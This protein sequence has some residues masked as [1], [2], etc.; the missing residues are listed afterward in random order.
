MEKSFSSEKILSERHIQTTQIYGFAKSHTDTKHFPV[1]FLGWKYCLIGIG[2]PSK[3]KKKKFFLRKL[4]IVL[5]SGC[6]NLGFHQ[7][8]RRVPFSPSPLHRLLFVDFL[9]MAILTG[10]RCYLIVVLICISL[11]ISETEHLP[12]C[13]LAICMKSLLRFLA[14]F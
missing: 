1:L 11:I 12:A 13:P 5:H 14:R 2:T 8:C 3:K 4:H 7:Q 10:V 9:M 6:I